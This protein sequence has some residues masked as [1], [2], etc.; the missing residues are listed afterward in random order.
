M[1]AFTCRFRTLTIVGALASL[2]T[3]ASDAHAAGRRNIYVRN[4]CNRPIELL[5]DHADGYHNWH[6]HAWFRFAA[7]EGG[8]LR[9][10]EG[11]ILSQSED[12]ELYGYARTTDR[13]WPLY[14][15]GN[16]QEVIWQGAAYKE[17]KLNTTVDSDGD[18]VV[19]ITCA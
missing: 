7:G 9:G 15:E 6:P 8:Y 16:E 10:S 3:F 19:R 2:A 18:L 12:H 14:W 4:A 1:I 17:T 5:I 13:G 11:N